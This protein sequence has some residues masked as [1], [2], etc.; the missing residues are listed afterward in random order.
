VARLAHVKGH[1][2]LLEAVGRLVH[3]GHP[4]RLRL[5]GDGPDRASL[6]AR[7]RQLEIDQYVV[8]EG[9]QTQDAVRGLYERADAFVLASLAEGIPVVLMEAMA[10]AIPCVATWVAGIPE[11][12]TDGVDGLLTAPS[13]E[14]GLVRAI[15]ALHQ[16]PELCRRLGTAARQKI[17]ADYDLT[18]NVGR[19]AAI[20][21]R[22]ARP[23]G[24]PP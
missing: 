23:S 18:A 10:M 24:P 12:I 15:S 8:F 19:L 6:E 14:D 3:D 16:D 11:L 9:W 2:H 21:R 4:V 13:D 7:V 5:V 20:L 1:R 22:Q 17:L